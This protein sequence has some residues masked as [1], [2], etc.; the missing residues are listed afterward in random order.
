MDKLKNISST[1][2]QSNIRLMTDDF[3]KTEYLDSYGRSQV[4][5][6]LGEMATMQ[7]MLKYSV[8]HRAKFILMFYRMKETLMNMFKVKL[9]EGV[10]P[11]DNILRQYVYII[12]KTMIRIELK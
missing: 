9:L 11:Q 1:L 8:E 10:L 5:Y 7:L 2:S 12:K 3:V 6:E 4:E